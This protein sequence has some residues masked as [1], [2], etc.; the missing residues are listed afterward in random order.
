MKRIFVFSFILMFI[1]TAPLFSQELDCKVTI[2]SIE[3]IQSPQRD[4]LRNFSSD[5]ERYLNNTRFTNEDLN[6]EKIVCNIEITFK[7]GSS[8]NRY[9]AQAFI[10]SQRPVYIV[11]DVS[12]RTTPILRIM[13]N[14]WE[15]TYMPNQRMNHDEM[16]FDPLTGF[17]DFYAYLIIGYDL[18][19]YVP[20]SGNSCFQKAVNIVR[21]AANSSEANDWKQ[22][23]ASY[24][25]FGISDELTNMKYDS[26]RM[27]FND[28]HYDGIDLLATEQKKAQD[29]ILNALESIN[30][31]QIRQSRNS[32]IIKQFF[33]AKS[34]EIAEVFQTYPDRSIYDK[35]SSFDEEN[36]SKYQEAKAK[37]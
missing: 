17:L 16:I 24:S 25:K 2:N 29:N 22:T 36:R 23:S 31:I 10:A 26:F 35:L 19:T 7:S 28:Y 5:V 32:I 21:L 30:E 1:I 15:F 6:G 9:Q 12:D 34:R 33:D 18:E 27:A 13:D 37:P 20:M 14:N 3:S 11:N 8:N 4:Y